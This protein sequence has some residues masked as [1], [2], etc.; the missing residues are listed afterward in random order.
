MSNDLA[1]KQQ[2]DEV[3][4]LLKA[5]TTS[6]SETKLLLTESLKRVETLEV[7]VKHLKT[8][9]T[10]LKKE[11]QGLKDQVN[12]RNQADRACSVRVFGVPVGEEEI[13][14]TDGGD[15]LRKRVYDRLIKPVLTAAKAAGDIA[16][17]PHA[18]TAVISIHRAGKAS[19]NSSP[20]L[21]YDFVLY[22]LFCY[23]HFLFSS[24]I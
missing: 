21:V 15:G 4:N 9:V 1:T 18:S 14:A 22:F 5:Q 16:T 10:S 19:A 24:L 20:C 11:V 6:L 12:S 17:V 8:S 3:L 2:L 23:L 7:E 13:G